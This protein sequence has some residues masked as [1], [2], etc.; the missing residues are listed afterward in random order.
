MSR[1]AELQG[2]VRTR[3]RVA[4]AVLTTA[5][6]VSRFGYR[7]AGVRYDPS[8]LDVHLQHLDNEL[9]RTRLLES[10]WFQHTQPPLFNLLIGL[11]L[12]YSPLSAPRTFHL[13][14]FLLGAALVAL[15]Y[16]VLRGLRVPRTVA[17]VATVVITCS[18][19]VILYE[20]WLS[21]EYPLT[22]AL[23]ALG[24]CAI[25]WAETGRL[26]WLGG[27]TVLAAGGVLT[28][29]LLHP[30]WYVGVVVLALAARRPAGRWRPALA[31]TMVPALL[32]GGVVVKN[33]VLFDTTLLSSWAGWNLQRVTI[34][35]LPEETRS[36]LIADGTL[37]P[38]AERPVFL[39]MDTYE[40][41]M[42][43]CTPAHPDVPVL[44]E[45][46]KRTGRENFNHECYL[47]VYDEALDN[48]VA[49]AR[50]E[51]RQTLR[52]VVGSFQI[53]GESSSQYA[54]VYPNR[55]EIDGFDAAYRR[56]VLLDVPYDAPVR[57]DAGWWI[58]L[59]R[60]DLRRRLSLTIVAA[61]SVTVAAGVRGGW[62]ALRGRAS[63]VDA[64]LA[65]I[66]FTVLAVTLSGNL[67]EIGENNRFR[68][69][70]EPLTLAVFVWFLTRVAQRLPRWWA[71]FGR[72][73]RREGER[74][75]APEPSAGYS[76]PNR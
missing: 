68:F 16:L 41:L 21:Y 27:L 19:T 52:A 20:N 23:T 71:T 24:L 64:G 53:W 17:L 54:F 31:L 1:V 36:Q 60:P 12:K 56:V 49:A 45:E 10:L 74:P 35:E 22:V 58:P 70:V 15:V 63:P 3:D 44:A 61:T 11:V 43:P 9:L 32:I 48:A 29:A 4:V 18:P 67:F 39:P 59:D 7:L 6:V 62:R 50:A 42:P 5:F 40:D 13:L 47:P 28:R 38:L 26:A 72:V 2:W 75:S 8:L 65:V 46:F 30:L 69:V 76:M 34:D 57:T 51:P 55:L 73:A 14:W 37:T 33:V 25:R 66:G